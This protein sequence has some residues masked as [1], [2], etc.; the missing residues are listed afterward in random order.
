MA[1]MGVEKEV[2]R[3]LKRGKEREKR[4]D[5]KERRELTIDSHRQRDEKWLYTYML[6]V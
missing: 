5:E 2:E 1:Q 6:H 4:R 3:R